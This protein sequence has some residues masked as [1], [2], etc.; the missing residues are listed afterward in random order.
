MPALNRISLG[1]IDFDID[2]DRPGPDAATPLGPFGQRLDKIG[3][4]N[5]NLDAGINCGGLEFKVERD[6]FELTSENAFD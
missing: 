1:L 5:L 2:F 4:L 6:V 3:N